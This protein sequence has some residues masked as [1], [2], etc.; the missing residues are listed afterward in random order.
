[1]KC[2]VV[3]PFSGFECSRWDWALEDQFAQESE[4]LAQSDESGC[5]LEAS[6]YETI[7]SDLWNEKNR[8]FQFLARQYL[9]RFTVMAREELKF[10][11]RLEFESLDKTEDAQ[12]RPDRIFARIGI[13]QVQALFKRS[14]ADGHEALCCE[15][16]DSFES[17]GAYFSFYNSDPDVLLAKPLETWDHNELGALLSA[18]LRDVD[19]EEICDDMTE[20]G[21]FLEAIWHSMNKREFARDVK[22]CRR[23]LLNEDFQS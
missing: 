4:D 20:S 16:K 12:R 17:R 3:I 9:M 2:L 1:M 10:P 23:E 19:E 5:P 14:T 18:V 13:R 11:L 15:V 6:D 7:I 8:G 22:A 21:D